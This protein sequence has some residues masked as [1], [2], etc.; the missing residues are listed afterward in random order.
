MADEVE[1]V[2]RR[3]LMPTAEE[4]R[5]VDWRPAADVYA[6]R[7]GWLVK[8]DLAGVRPQDIE[9]TARGGRLTVRGARRDCTLEE[10]QRHYSLEISY[11]RFERSLD[12]PFNV[13]AARITTDYR[14]GMLLVHLMVENVEA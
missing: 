14:D 3:L 12:L 6:T 2:L 11:N 13:E 10:G 4:C 5:R 8:F 9:V 1:N 7:C